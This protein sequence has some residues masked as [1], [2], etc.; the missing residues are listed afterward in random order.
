MN[1]NGCEAVLSY[2]IQQLNQ[3]IQDMNINEESVKILTTSLK[4]FYFSEILFSEVK[5][6]FLSQDLT[7][8]YMQIPSQNECKNFQSSLISYPKIS[9][10]AMQPT[11]NNANFNIQKPFNSSNLMFTN[12]QPI[13]SSTY[14]NIPNSHANPNFNMQSN[15]SFTSIGIQELMKLLNRVSLLKMIDDTP[16]PAKSKPNDFSKKT[17]PWSLKEDNRLLGAIMRY[18]LDNWSKV[19][20]F[21]GNNRTRGQCSQ[22]WSRGLNPSIS[23]FEWSPQE[24]STLLNYVQIHGNKKWS[25]ISSLIGNRS[26]VQCRYRYKQLIK[27]RA[28]SQT[29]LGI[30]PEGQ[31]DLN[32]YETTESFKESN[33]NSN[34]NETEES[35][36]NTEDSINDEKHAQVLAVENNQPH[37]LSSINPYHNTD[38]NVISINN[39]DTDYNYPSI[40]NTNQIMHFPNR[41]YSN[42]MMNKPPNQNIKVERIIFPMPNSDFHKQIPSLTDDIDIDTFLSKFKE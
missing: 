9:P 10:L 38:F 14:T 3:I 28:R 24:D 12:P 15:D 41:N 21:V 26:D 34:T 7:K 13:Q 23:R 33:S 17:R 42:F 16:I 29:D 11:T 22:R 40:S 8:P 2:L 6:T 30:S 27:K 19:S 20:K 1:K 39:I 35:Y 37:N 36:S 31:T 25:K 32:D 5:N 4:Q 18:G